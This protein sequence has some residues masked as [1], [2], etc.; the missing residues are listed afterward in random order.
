[1]LG[2]RRRVVVE[3]RL[4]AVKPELEGGC[5]AVVASGFIRSDGQRFREIE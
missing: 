5:V 2:W 1:M 3:F 4:A